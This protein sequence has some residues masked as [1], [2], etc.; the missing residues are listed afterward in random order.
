M[1]STCSRR[2][3]RQ[4]GKGSQACQLLRTSAG[5]C[6]VRLDFFKRHELEHNQDLE[7]AASSSRKLPPRLAHVFHPP[8]PIGPPQPYASLP[9]QPDR[10][11]LPAAPAFPARTQLGFWPPTTHKQEQKVRAEMA[12]RCYRVERSLC[13][14]LH[15]LDPILSTG[16]QDNVIWESSFL[17][18]SSAAFLQMHFH[19][20]SHLRDFGNA[21]SNMH[22]S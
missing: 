16:I 6:M 9:A 8:R 13:Q 2:G 17:T 5:L 4:S 22:E 14:L 20:P 12:S 7:D 15:I 10:S 21:I 18:Q 11:N 1:L 19:Y 3:V